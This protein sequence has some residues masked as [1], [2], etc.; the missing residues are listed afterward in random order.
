MT[1]REQ[2]QLHWT[3]FKEGIE[4]SLKSLEKS[5]GLTVGLIKYMKEELQRKDKER[6]R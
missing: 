6:A 5:V 3:A 2:D 4:F 1:E